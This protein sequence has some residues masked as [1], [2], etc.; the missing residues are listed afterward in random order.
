[1]IHYK[2]LMITLALLF[3]VVSGAWANAD[4]T[5][6]VWKP[7]ATFNIGEKWFYNEATRIRKFLSKDEASTVPAFTFDE[8]YHEWELNWFIAFSRNVSNQSN[9]VQELVFNPTGLS[10]ELPAGKSSFVQPI[11]FKI[12]S[13]KGTQNDPYMFGLVYE[14]AIEATPVAQPTEGR[15]WTFDM[16]ASDVVVSPVFVDATIGSG[17]NERLFASLQDAFDDVK[18]GETIKLDYNMKLTTPVKTSRDGEGVSFTLDLNGYI[19][20][21]TALS[22]TCIVLLNPDDVMTI[23]DSSEKQTG[24]IIGFPEGFGKSIFAAGRYYFGPKTTADDIKNIWNEMAYEMGW[25]MAPGM[26]F[27]DLN[28]GQP[29]DDG[30]MVRLVPKTYDMAIGA[31][32]FATFCDVDNVMLDPQAPEDVG[33]YT[34]TS[35]DDQ[36]TKATLAKLNGVVAHNTPMIIYNGT[37]SE[38]SVK[39][40]ATTDEAS[41]NNPRFIDQF[42]GAYSTDLWFDEQA[43]AG[44]DFYLLSGGKAFAPVLGPGRLR[45]NQCCLKFPKQSGARTIQLVFED[46][47]GI[48]TVSG[49]PADAPLYDLNGRRVTKPAKKGIYIQNGRK[50]VR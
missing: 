49:S 43:M 47:T 19:I 42:V 3:T 48:T 46:A 13:G 22:G 25:E 18:D 38:Q 8:E 33:L 27:V 37:G 32:K 36:R 12:V 23:I 5:D 6:M 28:N 9:P 2:K 26:E 45:V 16:L 11:G 35:I 1:M 31:G 21:G 39:L 14:P 34:I 17:N 24:G 40:K 20:D 44:N 7:G 15:Q 10:F 4:L 30:F 50:V 29:D 41:D